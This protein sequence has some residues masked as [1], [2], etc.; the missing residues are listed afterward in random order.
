MTMGKKIKLK[1]QELGLCQSE[2][3]ELVGVNQPQISR[4]EKGLRNPSVDLL[5]KISK[6]LHCDLDDLTETEAS[7]WGM[8]C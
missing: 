1:R 2:L 3:A 8:G 7:I 6:V 4:I 5:L